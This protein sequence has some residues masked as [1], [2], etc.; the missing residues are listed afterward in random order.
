MA[1]ELMRNQGLIAASVTGGMDGV[2]LQALGEDLS[3]IAPAVFQ[4]RGTCA[5][6]PMAMEFAVANIC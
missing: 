3:R 6:G 4:E 2:L 1:P 5:D